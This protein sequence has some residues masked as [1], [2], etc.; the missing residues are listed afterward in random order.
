[1]AA[2]RRP[3]GQLPGHHDALDLV[4]ALI[5]LG[6]PGA[7]PVQRPAELIRSAVRAADPETLGRV[8]VTVQVA[9]LSDLPLSLVLAREV[10]ARSPSGIRDGDGPGWDRFIVADCRGRVIAKAK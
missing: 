5:D 10:H 1:M 6:D 3:G 2:A 4:G 9:A 7:V 8:S